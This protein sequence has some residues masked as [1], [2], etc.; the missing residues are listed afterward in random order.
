MRNFN[1]SELILYFSK[2]SGVILGRARKR[3]A[4]DPSGCSDLE[5]WKLRQLPQPIQ[6]STPADGWVLGNGPEPVRRRGHRFAVKT[7]S[8]ARAARPRK[9]TVGMKPRQ[10]K[11]SSVLDP[12]SPFSRKRRRRYPGPFAAIEKFGI[13]NGA[14]KIPD[15]CRAY[16]TPNSGKTDPGFGLINKL[17]CHVWTAPVG[18][19]QFGFAR[20]FRCR[21]R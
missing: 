5:R 9:T 12:L 17:R 13:H 16:R 6:P 11:C 21:G 18:Q 1:T 7:G 15:I 14:V 4:E 20:S 3:A 10:P 8:K 19:E 2:N